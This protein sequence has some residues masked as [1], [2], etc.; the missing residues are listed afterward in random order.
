MVIFSIIGFLGAYYYTR[1]ES[2]MGSNRHYSTQEI[3]R[4]R[5]LTHRLRQEEYQSAHLESEMTELTL[6]HAA[7]LEAASAAEVRRLSR[8][9]G[10]LPREGQGL[11]VILKDSAKPMLLGENPNI[12]IVHNTDIAQVVNTLW[13]GGATAIAINR[14]P[15]T[16][17]TAITCSGPIVIVNQVRLAPPFT[18]TALGNIKRMEAVLNQSGSILTTLQRYGVGVMVTHKPVTIPAYTPTAPEQES[19]WQGT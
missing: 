1:N 18:I 4:A 13:A 8:Y 11:E 6:R 19:P 5:A 9:V 7:Q 10:L 12:G 16:G 3:L 15:V 17:L 14:Q 2:R